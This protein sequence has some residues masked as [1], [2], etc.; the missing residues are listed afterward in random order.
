M[1]ETTN[2]IG[3]HI[4]QYRV[5]QLLARGGMAEVYIAE[6]TELKRTAVLKVMLPALANNPTF[7]ERFR[8]EAQATARLEHP[9]IVRIYGTGVTP[10]KRPFLAM[11]YIPGGSLQQRLQQLASQGQTMP[12]GQILHIARQIAAALQTAHD[13]GI[14][15]RDLKPSNILLGTDGTPFLA[16]L[17]LA[18]MQSASRLTRTDQIMGTPHYMPP[19][20]ITGGTVNGRSDLYAL[21]IILYEML[22]GT[23][24]FQGNTAIMILHQHVNDPPPSLLLRRPGLPQPLYTLVERCLQKQPEQRYQTAQQVVAILDQLLST[25]GSGIAATPPPTTPAHLHAP[26]HHPATSPSQNPAPRPLRRR[27]RRPAVRRLWPVATIGK[28]ARTTGVSPTTN[29]HSNNRTAPITNQHIHPHRR[30]HQQ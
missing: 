3:Q 30:Q 23:V 14:T 24:P 20:Q 5:T 27:R 16:D 1:T 6:D 11:Q 18:A 4:N 9:N 21:G 26:H 28:G 17:G 8:R 13:H 2:L 12:I 10:D 25:T 29:C 22:T 15:H 19:E 7:H